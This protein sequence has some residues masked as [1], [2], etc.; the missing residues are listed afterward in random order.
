MTITV[1]L[2]DDQALVRAGLS[3]IHEAEHDIEVVGEASYGDQAVVVTRQLRPD[4]L[5]MDVQMPRL[6]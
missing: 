4:F 5:L 1:V 2:V 3:M 6:D